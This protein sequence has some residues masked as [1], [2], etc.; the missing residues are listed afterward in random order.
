MTMPPQRLAI[1]DV[2]GTL[3]DSQSHILEAMTTA[4]AA[5]G[6]PLPSRRAVLSIVGLSLPE[7]VEW[8]APDLSTA[9]R[10]RIVNAYKSAF[11]P[12]RGA[13][14]PALYPGALAALQCLQ[15][16]GDVILGVATGNSRRGLNHLLAVHGLEGMF[17]TLQVADDHPSKPHPSMILAA[18]AETGIAPDATVMIGDTT[19]DM[20]MGRAAGVA[21]LGVGWGYHTEASLKAAGADLVV[22][23]YD[24]LLPAMDGIWGQR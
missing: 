19:F 21:T 5:E 4:F 15:T 12:L 7:A 10:G 24:A 22:G 11:G 1:F 3:V 8:L 20:E 18:L 6:A 13:A 17:M 23:G 9:T 2:D 14:P 16:R